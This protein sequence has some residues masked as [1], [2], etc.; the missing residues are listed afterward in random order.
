MAK[1]RNV[2]M[3][4]AA[5]T[6]AW[7]AMANVLW[8]TANLAGPEDYDP[9]A[10]YDN[11]L[12]IDEWTNKRKYFYKKLQDLSILSS[13]RNTEI[14]TSQVTARS[15]STIPPSNRTTGPSSSHH[16]SFI[17][18]GQ[19]PNGSPSTSAS[20]L[21]IATSPTTSF[22]SILLIKRI[23]LLYLMLNPIQ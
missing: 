13:I 12:N 17:T 22:H 1:T 11:A 10:V 16:I 9:T 14:I 20:G 15:P 23:T 19:P 3:A 8:D 4:A 5:A 6:V 18:S 2:G 21:N 7:F